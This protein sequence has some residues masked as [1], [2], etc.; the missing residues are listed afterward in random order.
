MYPID[1]DVLAKFKQSNKQ[2]ARLTFGQT[3]ITEENIVENG[4]SI[5]RYCTSGDMIEI[6]STVSAEMNVILDNYNGDFSDVSFNGQEIFVEVGVYDDNDEPQYIPMGYFR[7]DGSPRK[8]TR[9]ALTAL[10]RMM[11]FEKSINT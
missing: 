6:G 11:N 1:S 3:T 9:I 5:N 8:L 7:V 4:L 2:L 10:D